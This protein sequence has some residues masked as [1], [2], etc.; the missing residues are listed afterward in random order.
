MSIGAHAVGMVAARIGLG[1]HLDG[2][3]WASHDAGFATDTLLLL[4]LNAVVTFLDGAVGTYAGAGSIFTVAAEEC[5]A[6]VF[7][8]DDVDARLELRRSENMLAVIVGHY[9]GDLTA[10]TTDAVVSIGDDKTIHNDLTQRRKGENM[11]GIYAHR[12]HKCRGNPY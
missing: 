4:D 6:A 5:R 12:V 10:T 2:A 8:F 3:E 9:A 7:A 1:D 11:F